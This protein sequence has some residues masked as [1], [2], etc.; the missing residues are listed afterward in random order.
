ME[1]KRK[2]KNQFNVKD[3]HEHLIKSIAFQNFEVWKNLNGEL[4]CKNETFDTC[5]ATEICVT[6]KKICITKI[7]MSVR[8][9]YHCD[10]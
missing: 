7:I 1:R 6:L 4:L 10:G 9:K 3:L 8:T 2:K 5:K